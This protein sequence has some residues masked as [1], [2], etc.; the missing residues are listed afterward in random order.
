MPTEV[1]RRLNQW[2]R[3]ERQVS[4]PGDTQIFVADRGTLE[5]AAAGCQKLP[6]NVGLDQARAAKSSAEASGVE[7]LRGAFGELWGH[8][9]TRDSLSPVRLA[10]WDCGDYVRE[11]VCFHGDAE[12]LIPA[13][14]LVPKGPE[15]PLPAVIAIHGHSSNLTWGKT[16]VCAPRHRNIA[17]GYGIR[18]VQRGYV[19]I[20]ID[21][22]GA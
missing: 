7:D 11:K 4:T 17:P 3:D 6:L 15:P 1:M 13:Y 14:I 5:R 20:A 21:L 10:A 16:G 12:Y 8:L 9:P 22:V 2:L 18:L 19:V